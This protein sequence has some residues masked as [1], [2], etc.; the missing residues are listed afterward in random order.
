[1][2]DNETD[3][4]LEQRLL[5]VVMSFGRPYKHPAQVALADDPGMLVQPGRDDHPGDNGSQ[6]WVERRGDDRHEQR[7]LWGAGHQRQ[8]QRRRFLHGGRRISSLNKIHGIC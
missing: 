2:E 7:A 6:G 5:A 1:M 4:E 3:R 8:I